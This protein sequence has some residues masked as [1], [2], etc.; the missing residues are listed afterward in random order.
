MA[1]SDSATESATTSKSKRSRCWRFTISDPSVRPFCKGSIKSLFFDVSDSG[2]TG[3]VQYQCAVW[4]CMT[5]YDAVCVP[6]TTSEFHE[7]RVRMAHQQ[8]TPTMDRT[9]AALNAG[10]SHSKYVTAA[11]EGRLQD[12]PAHSR[13]FYHQ[14]YNKDEARARKKSMKSASTAP[15]NEP[16]MTGPA[17]GYEQFFDVKTNSFH[18]V[19]S[20]SHTYHGPVTNIY[21]G[22]VNYHNTSCLTPARHDADITEDAS[23]NTEST[24][25]KK[26]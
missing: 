10:V 6:I 9:S 7:L 3:V 18:T 8:G 14:R 4:Q 16:D 1:S 21:G 12:L 23:V 26:C 13:T 24:P 22:T 11:A 17:A 19:E 15:V 20:Q 5:D 25:D 2:I